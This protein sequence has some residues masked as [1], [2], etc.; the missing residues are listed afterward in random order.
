MLAMVV[1]WDSPTISWW[2]WFIC[3]DS[4][5]ALIGIK[6]GCLDCHQFFLLPF[7]EK[8]CILLTKIKQHGAPGLLFM[9]FICGP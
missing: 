4:V 3:G 1:W 9:D 8:I 5:C 6:V 2:W 7:V